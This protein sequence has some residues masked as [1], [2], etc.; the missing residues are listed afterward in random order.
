MTKKKA[1]VEETK[2]TKETEKKEEV[3]LK[4]VWGMS[5][6]CTDDVKMTDFFNGSI[7][8]PVCSKHIPEHRDIMIL[9]RNGYDVQE[10][11]KWTP[12]KRREEVLVLQLSG[13]LKP[14]DDEL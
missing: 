2:D 7:T 9:H 8:I 4:C 3:K 5:P 12:E 10:F 11:L 13:L 14:G 1:V 6:G